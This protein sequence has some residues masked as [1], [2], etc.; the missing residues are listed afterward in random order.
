MDFPPTDLMD[1]DD[2]YLKTLELPRPASPARPGC[3]SADRPRVH[4]RHRAPV[5]GVLNRGG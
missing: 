1:Q 2:C 4:R 5:P 3:R